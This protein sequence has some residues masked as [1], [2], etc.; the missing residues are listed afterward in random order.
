MLTLLIPSIIK[1]EGIDQ[2]INDQFMP[3]AEWW[4]ALVF[5]SINLFGMTMPIVVIILVCGA[6][7]FTI[8]FD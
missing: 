5:T 7:F 3:I 1:A 2:R 4:E 6:T 8:Y